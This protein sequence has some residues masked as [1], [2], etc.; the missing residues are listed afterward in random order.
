MIKKFSYIFSKI[1]HV[2]QLILNDRS[3]IAVYQARSA[4]SL[5]II[6]K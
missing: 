5:D 3:E 1:R 2:R 4:Y 6:I